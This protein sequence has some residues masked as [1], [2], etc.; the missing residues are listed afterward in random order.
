VST[1]V[2]RKIDKRFVIQPST[3]MLRMYGPNREGA[4][5]GLHIK[6]LREGG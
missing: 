1:T 4:N 2:Q 6:E 5:G 3:R